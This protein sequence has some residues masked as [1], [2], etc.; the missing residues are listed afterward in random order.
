MVL[1]CW[2]A[3]ATA[4]WIWLCPRIDRLLILILMKLRRVF[5]FALLNN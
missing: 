3:L 4:W 5:R 1:S 2:F